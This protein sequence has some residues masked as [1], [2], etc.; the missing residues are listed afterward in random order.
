M[1]PSNLTYTGV[2]DLVR[3]L[4]R[5][6]DILFLCSFTPSSYLAYSISSMYRKQGVVTVLGGPHAR[7]YPDDAQRH[8]DYVLG[9]TDRPLIEDILQ[10]FSAHPGEGVRLTAERQP[11]LLPGVRER[12]K[13]IRHNMDK[14]RLLRM[15]PMIGSLGCPYT[16]SFCID[17][18]VDYQPLPYDQMREDLAFIQKELRNPIV[19][20][21]DPNFGVRFDDYMNLIEES[22]HPR[23]D[24]VRC[25]EHPLPAQRGSP[26]ASAAQRIQG[27]DRRP[28]VLVRLQQQGETGQPRRHGQGR[29]SGRAREPHR[30]LRPLRAGQLHLRTGCRRWRPTVCHDEEV[31]SEWWPPRPSPY[32]PC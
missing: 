8:F 31:R 27:D 25:G 4:P 11:A 3:D 29:S 28:G 26:A 1:K 2:E 18:S 23:Q 24:P 6:I 19:A 5:D 7:S 16:C 10:G 30:S 20:W 15:V 32:T 12:W 9:F 17:S 13:F 14:A 21:H 22:T